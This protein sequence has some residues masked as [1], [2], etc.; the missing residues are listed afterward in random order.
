MTTEN[1]LHELGDFLNPILGL[2]IAGKVYQ[3]PAMSA[4]NSLIVETAMN[5]ARSE[6][7]SMD[8]M[9]V[10]LATEDDAP[11]FMARILG[12]A[13]Q[14][15]LD[16]GVSA[17][18]LKHVTSIVTLWNWGGFDAAQEYYR[19]GG[20][21]LPARK[22]PADHKPKTGTRTRTG[23]ANTTRKPASQSGTSTRKATGSKAPAAGKSSP[24]G[25]P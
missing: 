24:T 23:A 4:Q 21:A 17:P 5:A 14:E 16:G 3:I 18:A 10:Q 19:S 8:P 25:T 7:G 9:K 22:A 20:K 15:M 12:P 2:P 11:T 1:E 6:D 13:Y